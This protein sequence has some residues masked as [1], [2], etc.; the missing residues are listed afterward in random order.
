MWFKKQNTILCKIFS[1]YE[2]I[3]EEFLDENLWMVFLP[4]IFLYFTL[5][6]SNGACSDKKSFAIN[7][8]KFLI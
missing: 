4:K 5:P 7:L 8:F 1:F 3:P 2:G 6:T